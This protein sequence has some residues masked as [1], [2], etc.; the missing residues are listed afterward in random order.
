MNMNWVGLSLAMFGSS[1]IFYLAVKKLQVMGLN[2]QVYTLA[3][4]LFPPLIFAGLAWRQELSLGLPLTI[5]AQIFVLRVVF[6]YAGTIA[7]YK[8]M[9]KAPNAGY[10]LVIQKG[11]GIYT[12]FAAALLFGSE[13]PAYKV[14][15]SFFVLG[16]TF[17]VIIDKG[18]IVYFYSV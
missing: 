9:E 10:S 5:L 16:C 14:L 15:L 17:L 12:L 18:K 7:G 11:Y 1:I 3:N 4:Y 2:K 8:S 13:L 6:N